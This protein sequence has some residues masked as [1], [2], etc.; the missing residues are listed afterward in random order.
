MFK[1]KEKQFDS[2]AFCFFAGVILK[3]LYLAEEI[4]IALQND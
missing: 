1:N 3:N 2:S 4:K